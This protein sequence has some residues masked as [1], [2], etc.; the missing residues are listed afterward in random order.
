MTSYRK[1]K[2]IPTELDGINFDSKKEARRYQD[3]KLL[4]M[5]N[6]ISNLE[7]QPVIP[8]MVNGTKIGRYTGD[9]KYIE[10]G[11]EIIEDVKSTA[12]KTRDYMLRK[13]ILATYNPP[14][15][16]KEV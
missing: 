12:T 4:Q 2:N 3:L 9:F 6:V 1:Y 13:K 16:I 11:K 15:F 8:L 5:G 7:I 14:I 10:N